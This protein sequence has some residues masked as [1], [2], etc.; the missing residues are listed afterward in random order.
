MLHNNIT[1]F[2]FKANIPI[3]LCIYI[4]HNNRYMYRLL[5]NILG[6]ITQVYLLLVKNNTS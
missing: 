2:K 3:K 6:I 4:Y 5:I 1:Y